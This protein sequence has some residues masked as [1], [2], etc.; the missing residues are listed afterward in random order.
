MIKTVGYNK[1]ADFC[2]TEEQLY[3]DNEDKS[4]RFCMSPTDVS[5]RKKQIWI[6]GYCLFYINNKGI[7]FYRGVTTRSILDIETNL[8]EGHI[9]NV[10]GVDMI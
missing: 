1:D 4:V 10:I 6:S 9:L 2:M 5:I 3:L 7:E 8:I